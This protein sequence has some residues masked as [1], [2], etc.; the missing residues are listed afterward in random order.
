MASEAQGLFAVDHEPEHRMDPPDRCKGGVTSTLAA[1]D[2]GLAPYGP[3]Q[4][5]QAR[6]RHAVAGGVIPGVLLL[7]EHEPVITLGSRGAES[8]LRDIGRL[9]DRAVAVARSERG[10]QATLHAPGQLVSYPIVPIPRRD[11]GAYVRGLEEILI[12][13][14]GEVGVVARRRESHP[15][16]YVGENKIASVGLRCQRWVASHGTS[17]NVT[18]DLSLFDLMISCGEPELK[19]TSLRVATGR[20]IPME[21]VKALYIEAARRVFGWVFS[22]LRTASYL[23]VDTLLGLGA[24]PPGAMPTA[25]FEPAAPGSGGQ[26]SIP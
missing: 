5:L 4:A 19:Q 23:E 18:I 13:L 1:L 24:T 11:L 6:L 7:L 14:L 22:P 8:D 2:L 20:D 16:V 17:L 15:G 26:C 21:R 10:G 9:R 12:V 25:G 3:V